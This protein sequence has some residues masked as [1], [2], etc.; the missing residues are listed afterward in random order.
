MALMPVVYGFASIISTVVPGSPGAGKTYRS[1]KSSRASSPGNW[2]L[3][4]L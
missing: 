3:A 4:A 2:R 1:V